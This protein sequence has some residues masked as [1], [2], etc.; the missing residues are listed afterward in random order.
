M[1]FVS[2]VYE[3]DVIR[4]QV[5]ASTNKVDQLSVVATPGLAARVGEIYRNN[6]QLP[7]GAILSSAQANLTDEQIKPMAEKFC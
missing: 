1:V 5:K 3:E 4:R 6:P 7:A 2:S